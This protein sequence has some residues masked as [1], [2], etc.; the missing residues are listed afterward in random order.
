MDPNQQYQGMSSPGGNPYE[1]ILNPEPPKRKKLLG[2]NKLL[3]LL[4]FIIG[5]V[6]AF[7]IIVTILLN[8]LAPEKIGKA[9]FTSLA[10]T[11]NELIRVADQGSRDSRQQIT[12]NLAT[13]MQYTMITQQKLTLL[14]VGKVGKKELSLKQNA[15]TDQKLASAKQT[16]T[17]DD[18]FTKI[19][20]ESLN[21]YANE[22]KVLFDKAKTDADRELMSDFY[23]QAQLL[24]AQI[25]YAKDGIQADSR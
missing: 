17:F 12:K 6:V 5:G 20:E 11:Q 3:K 15:A 19:A 25:P 7:M 10:Q 18:A 9:E 2:G 22:V 13:T 16:S 1:F 8:V 24:I 4:I 23:K 14:K 21:S